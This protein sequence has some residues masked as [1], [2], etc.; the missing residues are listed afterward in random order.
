MNT[1]DIIK[2]IAAKNTDIRYFQLISY[3]GQKD[4]KNDNSGRWNSEV[5]SIYK[6]A[7]KLRSEFGLPFWNSLM[8]SNVNNPHWSPLCFEGT[9]QHNKITYVCKVTPSE[10]EDVDSIFFEGNRKAVNS[11]V[12]LYNGEILHLPMLDFHIPYNDTNT[13]IVKYVSKLIMPSGYI[14]K[15]GKSYHLIGDKLFTKEEMIKLLG[16]ALL[17]SPITD[18][19]WIAH[20]L[21]DKSCSL[22]FGEKHG[23]IPTMIFKY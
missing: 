15:S 17:F 9:S 11:S 22:R 10:L 7:I 20:Q 1:I 2:E 3:L 8:L 5:E 23:I 16:K 12:T 21:Q 4:F 19:I 6:N 14:L 13:E 18:E